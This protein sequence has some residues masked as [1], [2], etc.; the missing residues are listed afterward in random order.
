MVWPPPGATEIPE[1]PENPEP[2]VAAEPEEPDEPVDVPAEEPVLCDAAALP[3]ELPEPVVPVWDEPG[4]AYATTP[5]AARPAT[6]IAT[7]AARSRDWPCRRAATAAA[8]GHAGPA[9]VPLP[10]RRAG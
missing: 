2:P 4:R 1:L 7:V 9:G 10:L 3:L 8:T 6:P 5:A